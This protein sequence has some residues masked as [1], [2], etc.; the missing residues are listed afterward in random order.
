MSLLEP[1]D[2]AFN[3]MLQLVADV[4]GVVNDPGG[5]AKRCTDLAAVT[6]AAEQKIVEA[7]QARRGADD[8]IAEVE[9]E[10]AEHADK[11]LAERQVLQR[12]RE[13]FAKERAALLDEASR[14]RGQAQADADQVANK[15]KELNAKL[16]AIN[17]A[18]AA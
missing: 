2:Q 5:A 11:M 10:L 9:R 18:A 15:L 1:S 16:T 13:S 14:L 8:R 12:E 17:A 7:R 6:S 4:I 3:R